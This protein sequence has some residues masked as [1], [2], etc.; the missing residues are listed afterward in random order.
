MRQPGICIR[1][2]SCGFYDAMPVMF[3]TLSKIFWILAAPSHW[4]G[5][6]VLAIAICLL[7]RWYRAAKFF[8]VAALAILVVAWLAAVPLVRAWEDR[9]P[10]PPWPA[11]VDGILVL[12]SGFDSALLRERKAPSSNGGAYRLVEGLAA[13]RHYPQARLVFTG[14]SGALAGSPFPESDTA[15]Y[16]FLELGAD[17][18]HVVLES[19]SRNTY[20]NI[21]FSKALIKPRPGEVWLLATSAMHM[22]RAMAIAKK[23]DWPMTPW[24]TDFLTGSQSGGDFWGIAGNLELLDYAIHEWIGLAAYRLSGKAA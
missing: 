20:E 22:P 8:A 9:Y 17:P 7:L 6:L 10:R 19:R 12:G 1:L 24:P 18:G 4:V 11:H 5:M 13:A 15:R 2:P 14:G 23:L 21:L 16:V 3:F